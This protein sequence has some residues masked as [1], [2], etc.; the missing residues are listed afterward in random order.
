M[1]EKGNLVK[2]ALLLT[3]A[4]I[5]SKVLSAGY[6]VPLQNLTGDFGFYIY[7]QVY[8]LLG[9][10]LILSLYGFPS[11]VSK[12]AVDLQVKG[13]SLSARSFYFPVFIIMLILNGL[14]FLLLYISSPAIAQVIGDNNLTNAYRLVAFTFL[15]LP[16]T[17][18]LRGVFQ[19]THDMKP[20]AYSQVGEQVIRVGIIIMVAYLF[21]L[22]KVDVYA[23]G[24]TAAL[25]S[26]AGSFIACIILIFF[27][28]KSKPI[29]RQYFSIP[30]KYYLRTILMLGLVA[31]LNHMILLIVQFADVFTLV[32][33]LMKHGLSTNEA[34][35][36][37]GVFDRG[38]PLIQLGAVLGSSFALALIPTLSYQKMKFQ[39][40]KYIRSIRGAVMICFYLAAG[41]MI[42]LIML[43]PEINTLLYKNTD[44]TVSLQILAI[45]I[46]LSS[47][48]I[49]VTSILQ[50]LGYYR[51]TALYIVGV[52]IIKW[53]SNQLFVPLWG[54]TGS[55]IATVVS[56]L[57]LFICVVMEL[58]KRLPS[59]SLFKQINWTAF[60]KASGSMIVF[61]AFAHYVL[62]EEMIMSRISLLVYVLMLVFIGAVIYLFVLLRSN[63]FTESE[64]AMLP[65]S[66]K[67]IT[68]L[69]KE[70]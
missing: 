39:P 51:R 65:F 7:Q 23:I 49:T 2:G 59:L 42:G 29:T 46:L 17:S 9:I 33:N 27:F 66:S 34:M 21:T 3:I 61:L 52:F 67:L 55:A 53:T 8:P 5:V 1:N 31:S 25:A 37:K 36:A 26:I 12:I 57:F 22:G 68:L 60:L 40:H 10:I 35:I 58:R 18:L 47:I 32:P 64:L 56:L 41:A 50:G 30:W 38:Q 62:P 16:F 45:A 43:F 11:A 4:G 15:F 44:G 63:A 13:S 6:R 28:L 19:G 14:L 70:R 54:I 48:S 24:K 69:P 20:T